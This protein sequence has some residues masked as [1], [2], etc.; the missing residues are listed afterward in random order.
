MAVSYAPSAPGFDRFKSIASHQVLTAQE[1]V[2][3]AQRMEAGL[4]AVAALAGPQASQLTAPETARLR[5]LVTDGEQAKTDFVA[6]NIRL[7]VSIAARYQWRGLDIEDLVQEG[8][9]GLVRA[10]ELFDYRRGF[11]FSTFATWWIRQTVSRAIEDQSRT[12]RLPSHTTQ[13]LRQVIRSQQELVT[14]LGRLPTIPETAAYTRLAPKTVSLLLQYGQPTI[15]LDAPI[16]SDADL[17]L[18]DLV[19]DDL[20]SGPEETALQ[21]H[22]QSWV[23]QLLSQLRCKERDVLCRRFGIGCEP[24]TLDEIA[25]DYE[26]S[27]ERVRQI[28]IRALARLKYRLRSGDTIVLP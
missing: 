21:R 19:Q 13:L 25:Q 26:V 3:F 23:Q 27:R 1:E 15:S 18:I 9:F 28:E 22:E 4:A 20:D 16:D 24:Q 8:W 11:K 5:H 6:S 14:R 17:T 12:V 10:V 7:V 2:R